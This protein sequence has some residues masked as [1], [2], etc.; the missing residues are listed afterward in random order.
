MRAASIEPIEAPFIRHRREMARKRVDQ[1]PSLR[2]EISGMNSNG[3]SA[4]LR[5]G[6]EAGRIR[7]VKLSARLNEKDK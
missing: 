4:N 3:H 5:N 2:C 1:E 7:A 6:V